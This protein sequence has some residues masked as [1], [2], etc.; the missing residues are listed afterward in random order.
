MT[1][2]ATWRLGVFVAAGI[3]LPPRVALATCNAIP[4][5]E[6]VFAAQLG[7]VSTP[8][9]QPGQEVTV[10]RLDAAAF[11]AA[12]TDNQISLRFTPAGGPTTRLVVADALKLPPCDGPTCATTTC[13]IEDCTFT[14]HCTCVRFQFP[15][16][17]DQV[18]DPS[19]G[20]GLTGRV[21]IEVASGGAAVATIGAL[22]L[23]DAGA[24]GERVPDDFFPHFVALPASNLFTQLIPQP[25]DWTVADP[26][27]GDL[28]AA[29]DG[30]NLFVPVDW[31]GVRPIARGRYETLSQ[32][33]LV[34]VET[35]LLAALGD[36]RIDSV[37]PDGRRLAALI[38]LVQGEGRVGPDGAVGTADGPAQATGRSCCATW[39]GMPTRRSAPTA[40]PCCW[41]S[42]TRST[43]TTSAARRT[44]PSSAPT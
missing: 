9:A 22:F 36:R 7:A 24:G 43:R 27:G 25:D 23:P 26:P 37:G 2:A 39:S 13:R 42:A 1:A 6:R 10:R 29:S 40:R 12:P 5:P 15:D 38:R 32:V 3:L 30:T 17:D 16:T 8:F 35:P 11:S 33:P 44:T 14:G 20:R 21:T 41:V 34:E 28:L 18:G 4:A 19:D 31:T